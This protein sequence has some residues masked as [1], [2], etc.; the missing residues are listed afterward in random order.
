MP[1]AGLVLNRVHES[2][3]PELSAADSAAAA[4]EVS[5]SHP[6]TAQVLE[7][8]ELLMRQIARE[9]EVATHFTIS[10]PGTGAR[11]PAQPT[12]VHDLD[13]LRII[14]A[15]LGGSKPARVPCGLFLH[16]GFECAFPAAHGGCGARS[17]RRSRSVIPPQT[18]NSMRLSSASAR[19]SYRTGQ[20]RQIRL[21]TFCSAP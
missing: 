2:A 18:P 20:P 3:A 12:D 11:V 4:E 15:A 10:F 8:H 1:L 9:T 7:V 6:I 5:E 19:H 21:A 17:A 14:G 16:G 13:G